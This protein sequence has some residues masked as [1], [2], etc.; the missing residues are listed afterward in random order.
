M[1]IKH[2]FDYGVVS[3][4]LFSRYIKYPILIC[5]AVKYVGILNIRHIPYKKS[6][7]IIEGVKFVK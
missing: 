4:L 3:I 2:T 7:K 6:S 1:F 5:K